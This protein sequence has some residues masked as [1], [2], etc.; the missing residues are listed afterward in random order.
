MK[1]NRPNVVL[2]GNLAEGIPPWVTDGYRFD[3]LDGTTLSGVQIGFLFPEEIDLLIIGTRVGD[4]DYVRRLHCLA[5]DRNAQFL[6]VRTWHEVATAQ[7]INGILENY[8]KQFEDRGSDMS[9]VIDAIVA[10]LEEY[11]KL[12]ATEIR[13]L[14]DDGLKAQVAHVIKT[15]VQIKSNPINRVVIQP[16]DKKKH[17]V[18]SRAKYLYCLDPNAEAKGAKLPD[19]GTVKKPKKVEPPEPISLEDSCEEENKETMQTPLKSTS[20]EQV[21]TYD[22]SVREIQLPLIGKSWVTVR[23]S[24][25]L[26]E[27]EWVQMEA[28][29][30]AMKPGLVISSEPNDDSK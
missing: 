3:K 6:N 30:K 24:F 27:S 28:I 5:R 17:K 15:S 13:A 25:P 19:N 23:G 10:L 2:V 11:G 21:S 14:I 18:H 9:E 8:Q 20:S 16:G 7:P 29:L 12:S 4:H 1:D 22:S 26:T